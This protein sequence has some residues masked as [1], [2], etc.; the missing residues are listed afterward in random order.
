MA[1]VDRTKTENLSLYGAQVDLDTIPGKTFSLYN[2]DILEI[3]GLPTLL[4][5]L[6][7][8]VLVDVLMN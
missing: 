1:Q 6:I 4:F 8:P 2:M 5:T 7:Q 3:W